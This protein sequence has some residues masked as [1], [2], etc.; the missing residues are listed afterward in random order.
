[1]S[2]TLTG[3]PTTHLVIPCLQ[4][5]GSEGALSLT[6]ETA[7]CLPLMSNLRE[8]DAIPEELKV[9]REPWVFKDR[10]HVLYTGNPFTDR[11][12]VLYTMGS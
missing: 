7:D 1:M 12:H 2:S 10:L 3:Y 8:E 5:A 4:N 9:S 6:I 11:L